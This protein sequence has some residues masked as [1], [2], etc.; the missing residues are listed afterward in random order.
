MPPNYIGGD[1]VT[2]PPSKVITLACQR[3]QSNEALDKQH[4]KALPVR[5]TTYSCSN[6]LTAVNMTVLPIECHIIP[7]AKSYYF[8]PLCS[9]DF[10]IAARCSCS[11]SRD[12]GSTVLRYRAPI[13]RSARR[14][15]PWPP[16]HSSL[17][18]TYESHLQV[19]IP[20]RR[21]CNY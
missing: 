12:G 4:T 20:P 11:G 18:S 9:I 8:P 16:D 1:G 10:P 6:T 14:F 2:L 17:L 7:F 3:P 19:L 21:Q 15:F 13:E 5:L